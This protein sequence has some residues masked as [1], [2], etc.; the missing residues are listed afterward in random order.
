MERVIRRGGHPWLTEGKEKKM[1]MTGN[2]ISRGRLG[3]QYLVLTGSAGE[4]MEAE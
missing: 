3:W 2:T 4:N 1:M